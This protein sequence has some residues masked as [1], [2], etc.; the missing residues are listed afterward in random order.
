M[1]LNLIN[2]GIIELQNC[3]DFNNLP[4]QCKNH[5]KRA[6]EP[7]LKNQ[8]AWFSS[9]DTFLDICDAGVSSF[10]HSLQPSATRRLQQSLKA[11]QTIVHPG[12]SL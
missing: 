8:L 6:L 7:G 4:V 3:E 5:F 2:E 10:D 12:W 1:S 11:L 9:I